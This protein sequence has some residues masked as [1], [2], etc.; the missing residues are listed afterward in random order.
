MEHFPICFWI[1]HFYCKGEK[2]KGNILNKAEFV[3]LRE[4]N[5]YVHKTKAYSSHCKGN[6]SSFVYEVVKFYLCLFYIRV[7]PTW[8]DAS[9]ACPPF[10]QTCPPPEAWNLIVNFLSLLNANIFTYLKAPLKYNKHI[11]HSFT[12]CNSILFF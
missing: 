2:R 6:Y 11:I 10:S 4:K 8:C 12:V 9:Q 3:C 5:L 7:I 1:T